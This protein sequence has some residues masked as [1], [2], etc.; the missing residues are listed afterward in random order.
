MCKPVQLPSYEK[1]MRLFYIASRDDAEDEGTVL[2][3]FILNISTFK[4]GSLELSIIL[5][6]LNLQSANSPSRIAN[7]MFLVFVT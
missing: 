3:G 5:S 1:G 2:N 4:D 6:I 7:V